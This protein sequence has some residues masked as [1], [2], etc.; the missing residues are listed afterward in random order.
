MRRLGLLSCS[1]AVVIVGTTLAAFQPG[2]D[3][4]SVVYEG[5]R[6]ILG[7]A[8]APIGNGALVVEN[9]RIAAVGRK[10]EVAAPAGAAH[11]DLTGKTIIPAM[12]NAHVHIGYEGYTSWGAANHTLQNVLDHL[13]REAYYGVGAAQS[14]GSSP[15][16]QSLQIQTEQRAGRT[17]PAA[18]YYFMPGFAPPGGGP[19]AVLK[20]ATDALHVI[21]EVSTARDARAIVQALAKKN[22]RQVKI[23]V[24][25]RRGTYPKM[26]PEV[27][28]A[29]ID[30]AHRN[31]MLVNAH[32][33]TLPDQKAVVRAGAD[34][35]VHVVQ[36][37]KV[38]DELLALVKE[39]KPYWATVIGLG[40]RTEVC[41]PDPF[42]EEGLPPQV[43]EA[44]RATKEPRGLAPS[45]APPSPNAARREE[46]LSYNL[47]HMIAAGAR[48]VLGTD[49]GIHAGHTFGTGDHHELTRWVQLGVPP[50]DAIVAATSRPAALLGIGDMG[51][52]AAGKSADFVVLDANPLDDI[53]NTRRI[54]DVYLRGARLDRGA[55]RASWQRG[56]ASHDLK[57]LPE[58]VH[59]GYYDPA[60]KPVLRVASG[61]TVHVEAMLAR[62]LPRLY[63]AGVKDDEIPDALKVIERTI[64]E[65][66]PGAHPLAG[67]I[68][69][70]GAEPGDVLEVKIVGFEFLHPYGVS[71][72]IPGS[73]TLP[74]DFPY[75]KFRLVRFDPR[76]GTAQF[77]PGVTLKLAPF[78][79]SIGVAPNPLVGRISSGP[80]GPHAGNLDNKELVAGST[81]YIPV[82]VPGALLSM[83]DGHAMQGDGEVTLTALETSL[84]GTVQVTV[85]KNMRLRWP[86]AETPTHY[87]AMGLHTDLDEA[88][89]LATR[90]MIDFLVTEK[91]MDRDEAYVLCSIAADLH[92]TQL[93][94]GTKGV[95]AML[96]KSIFTR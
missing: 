75:A 52:L 40:D 39:K 17:P 28:E 58:N 60:V 37:E 6:L 81:L 90:E 70:E 65:R 87:I 92:V 16:D 27:Y 44:I 20:K 55:I 33:T 63:A 35:L 89:K 11:V 64:T 45:C 72:F 84:R 59:W 23:W 21:N 54:A 46:I 62:G 10:G 5:A 74:D 7:D 61:D 12:I 36:S 26:T 91:Q 96:A 88:A 9:G 34:V 95:H 4:R 42:F 15:T 31:R 67:P 56:G 2:G 13:R 30:E 85:R 86:R 3:A 51:T 68:F 14:V 77:A 41:E 80:P 71:G 78:W 29:I 1:A 66:G 38:D 18:R 47:Q 50:A 22:I 43:I 19:D 69:V 48:L 83:G 24:D 82:Q 25:D 49:T 32:A 73:G 79:G 93:V 76:A 57:L 53:R 8:S 94:D